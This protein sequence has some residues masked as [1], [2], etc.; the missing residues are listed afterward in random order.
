MSTAP[1]ARATHWKQTVFY[2]EDTLTVS[3]GEKVRCCGLLLLG[4]AA[5]G[6][7][8][9]ASC[10]GRAAGG[11]LLGLLGLGWGWVGWACGPGCGA[12]AWECTQRPGAP[13]PTPAQV[14]GKLA[15]KPNAKNPRDLDITV[16][17]KWHGKQG[18]AERSQEY[19][20]R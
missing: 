10:W 8:L 20:M 12:A 4:Q 18:E 19:R 3:A 5:G 2:L 7:L 11:E 9:G 17:Y 14:E 13:A 1:K 15:C 16:S 6:K